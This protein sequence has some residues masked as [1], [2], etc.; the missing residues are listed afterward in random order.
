[1]ITQTK[2]MFEM[3]GSR[4]IVLPA[5][6]AGKWTELDVDLEIDDEKIIIR[7]HKNG[8]TKQGG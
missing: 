3:G 6:P 1:M 8:D 5:N 7:P 4:C 2:K